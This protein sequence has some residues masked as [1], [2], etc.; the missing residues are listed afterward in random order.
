MTPAQ[1]DKAMELADDASEKR[2]INGAPVYNVIASKARTAL[3]NYLLATCK[4]SL[5]VVEPPTYSSTQA[6]KCA[7]CGVHK[8]T[9]L[10]VD[11]MG[12]YVCLTCI[13][14]RLEVLDDTATMYAKQV[15]HWIEKHDALLEQQL[16]TVHPIDTSPEHVQKSE[17]IE[18]IG[19]VQHDCEECKA[20]EEQP[21]Q[22][23]LTLEQIVSIVES[24]EDSPGRSH[25]R[26]LQLLTKA[27]EKHHGIGDKT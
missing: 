5:K 6:T 27:I 18:R 15:A 10:R 12:G 2:H 19:C 17:G 20:R 4:D 3:R 9:P 13:D 23:P 26:V 25:I 11:F 1:I 21:K 14:M 8:H 22:E 7:C 24:V 16:K